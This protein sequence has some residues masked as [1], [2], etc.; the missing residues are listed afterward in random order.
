MRR[1]YLRTKERSGVLVGTLFIQFSKEIG[2]D[3]KGLR[4]GTRSMNQYGVEW[5]LDGREIF[6]QRNEIGKADKTM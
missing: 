2:K 6:E 1:G 3:Q 4:I 5:K